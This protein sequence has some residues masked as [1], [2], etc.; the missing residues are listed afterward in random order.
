MVRDLPE[1]TQSVNKGFLKNYFDLVEKESMSDY[2]SLMMAVFVECNSI[3]EA[4]NPIASEAVAQKEISMNATIAAGHTG[5]E[6]RTFSEIA[7]QIG[8]S[9]DQ[10]SAHLEQMR[11]QTSRIVNTA[12]RSLNDARLLATLE[13]C[14][15]Q[16]SGENNQTLLKMRVREFRVR[17][18][19]QVQSIIEELFGILSSLKALDG[20]QKRAWA[21]STRLQI[22][23]SLIPE[24]EKQFVIPIA[25]GLNSSM[26]RLEP[27]RENLENVIRHFQETLQSPAT[28]K[29]IRV[30]AEEDLPYAS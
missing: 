11:E 14:L 24:S 15:P 7:K 4:C 25:E 9:S 12:L 10:L 28:W 22:E 2:Y 6:I 21:T 1:R 19:S 17:I 30:P 27:A 29:V 16:I 5:A 3:R 23:A 8:S 13:K 20:G 26:E 18:H